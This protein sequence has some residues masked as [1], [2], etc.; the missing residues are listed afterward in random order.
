MEDV[1]REGK[2]VL[3]FEI[4]DYEILNCVKRASDFFDTDKTVSE[5]FRRIANKNSVGINLENGRENFF[6]LFYTTPSGEV[7]RLEREKTLKQLG[8]SSKVRIVY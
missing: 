3:Y 6:Q 5:A 4:L 8:L 7:T 1:L 2:I